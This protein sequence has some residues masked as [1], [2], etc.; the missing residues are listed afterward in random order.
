MNHANWSTS[1]FEPALQQPVSANYYLSALYYG[2]WLIIGSTLLFLL[3]G[4]A[5]A[6][7]K[8]PVYRSDIL[9]QVEQSRGHT[10]E[11]ARRCVVDVRLEDRCVIR[12]RGIEVADG[13]IA[14][15]QQP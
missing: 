12:D 5:Y 7:F 1:S 13:H 4:I 8:Q 2:R 10:K 14:G 9:V 11:C 3:A 6:T 15:G